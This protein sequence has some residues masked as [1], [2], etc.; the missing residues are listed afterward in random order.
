MPSPPLW[1]VRISG[2]TAAGRAV[3]RLIA[4][5]RGVTAI[6]YALITTLIVMGL[7]ALVTQIGDFVSTPFQTVASH[8]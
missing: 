3:L 4:D 2:K 1:L 8:L 7:V 6:E 5:E